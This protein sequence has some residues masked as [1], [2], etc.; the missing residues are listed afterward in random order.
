MLCIKVSL[1]SD[2]GPVMG[3]FEIDTLILLIGITSW[4]NNLLAVYR[5][6]G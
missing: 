3:P 6:H 2:T 1:S 5:P 4:E